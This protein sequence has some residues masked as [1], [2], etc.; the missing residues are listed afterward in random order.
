M[1]R[2]LRWLICFLA[3]LAL[4]PNARPQN[5]E[6]AINPQSSCSR[7]SALG[8]IQRQ[9]DLGKTIDSD[10]KRITLT[11]RAA[12]LMWPADQGKARATFRSCASFIV[13]NTAASKVCSWSSTV[14]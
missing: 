13:R 8:I 14:L 5:K 3:I 9:I 2:S 7:D 10:A 4:V 11:L 12:D 1:I 6:T